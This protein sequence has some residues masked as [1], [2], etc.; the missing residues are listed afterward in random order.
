[1]KSPQAPTQEVREALMAQRPHLRRAFWFSVTASL[2][3]LAPTL[4]ML[5]VYDRVVNSRSHLTLVSLT[6]LVIGAYVVMEVLDWARGAIMV[7][8]GHDLEQ[9]LAGRVFTA[10]MGANL[11]RQA[12]GSQQPVNDLRTIRD[13]M[14][15]PVVGGLM[16]APTALVFLVLVFLINP[17]LGWMALVGAVV[18]TAIAWF[19]ER[20]TQ[21]PLRDANQAAVGAQ[22]YVDGTLRNA[23]VI[24]S[25]GMLRAVHG[26]WIERQREVLD[27]QALASDRGAGYQSSSKYV[28]LAL[29]SL[30]LGVS[31][32]LQIKGEFGA[33][34][35]M[36]IVASTL[37]GRIV[38]PVVQVVTQWRS[39]V[40]VRGA[41]ARLSEFLRQQPARERSMP[42]P[43]PRGVLTVENIVATPPGSNAQVIR[44]VA[45]GL[46]P[47]EVLAVVGPSASGKTSLARL[48]VGLWPTL[49]GKVRLDGVDLYN[50]D[51]AELGPHIGYL[52]QGVE[53]LDGSLAENIAR[54]GPLDHAKIEA[55]ARAVGLHEAILALPEGYDSPVG[56]DGARLSG[57]MRQR[58]AL[59]RALYGD[60]VLVVLDEPNSS[61]DEAGDAALA[62]AIR[63][64]KAKGTS[65]VVMTHRTAVLAVAD[66]MLIL[67]DGAQQAFGP[68]D[69]VLAALRKAAAQPQG[70]PPG[71]PAPV[72]ARVA[73]A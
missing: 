37:G 6:V 20:A 56:R 26:R 31:V 48:L 55:A 36:M 41:W 35:G 58:V 63:Q 73:T 40:N 2:L 61:L 34:G 3:V 71:R 62:E 28:Q 47:G 14:A 64:R 70:Q 44:N 18:V 16:E 72:P 4:Y 33:S 46:P 69:E 68:R 12:G 54:F 49:A 15:S 52:P 13:F 57:G 29:N 30:M 9:R 11:R 42:L 50:W 25:M 39:V 67:A 7:E 45:F 24:E 32:W 38:A 5:E 60:P 10:V 65:F 1:M 27:L 43:A 8:V 23:E 19:N 51:K 66:K 53:L 21:A 59:A 22:Q 17:K